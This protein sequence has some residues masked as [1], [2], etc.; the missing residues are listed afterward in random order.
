MTRRVS[1]VL[2]LAC[3]CVVVALCS[4]A[5]AGDQK[6]ENPYISKEKTTGSELAT[7]VAAKSLK[8]K[9]EAYS[10]E[11]LKQYLPG[12]VEGEVLTEATVQSILE[13]LRQ[14]HLD[15]Y[16]LKESTVFGRLPDAAARAATQQNL[17]KSYMN[18]ESRKLTAQE[19]KQALD[20]YASMQILC[21]PR[22]GIRAFDYGITGAKLQEY[23]QQSFFNVYSVEKDSPADGKLLPGDRIIGAF[24]YLF[25]PNEDPRIPAGYAIAEAQTERKGGRLILNVIRGHGDPAFYE[26]AVVKAAGKAGKPSKARG[27]T[28]SAGQTPADFWESN[29]RPEVIE[30]ALPLGVEGDYAQSWPFHCDKSRSIFNKT[31]QYYLDN[32]TGDTVNTLFDPFF[33]LSAD[34]HAALDLARRRLY[35]LD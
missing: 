32:Y 25:P 9:Y 28:Q 10:A 5:D 23:H 4:V 27:P 2:M 16:R 22:S 31:V 7:K 12:Q 34:S 24:G 6:A 1:I 14:Q 19:K 3:V 20:K 26:P 29:P 17:R 35:K 15:F 11:E 30:V 13:D 8:T 21:T 33:L 18:K